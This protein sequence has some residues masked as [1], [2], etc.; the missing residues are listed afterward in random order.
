MKARQRFHFDFVPV[1]G[2]MGLAFVVLFFLMVSLGGDLGSQKPESA[3]YA[4]FFKLF[5]KLGYTVKVQYTQLLPRPDGNLLVY[6]DYEDD[7]ES[8]QTV[9]NKW[10][11]PGGTVLLAGIS[12]ETDPFTK[13]SLEYDQIKYIFGV[14]ASGNPNRKIEK[15]ALKLKEHHL[16]HL[17]YPNKLRTEQIL[18]DSTH[19]PFLYQMDQ[20]R[21]RI[22][23][24]T[25]SNLLGDEILREGRTA[26]Y[27]NR[28]LGDY[29]PKR[30]YVM[31]ANAARQNQPVPLLALLFR[32]KL[33]YVTLQLLLLIALFITWQG[34][35]FGQPQTA[36]PYSRRTLSEHLKAVGNWYQ[37]T[38]SV[39]MV[40][41]INC[42]YFRSMI[43]KVTG[44]QLKEPLRP[45]ELEKLKTALA[46]RGLAMNGEQL[47]ESLT[48]QARI[49]L[50]G[51]QKKE[52]L[53]EQILKVL[54]KRSE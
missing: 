18:L 9:L 35:R 4:L 12:G 53:Q 52:K 44:L 6:F 32:G 11:K 23:V 28:L 21:G 2:V 7:R 46:G 39:A 51:L 17:P 19:G 24:L 16:K 31:D 30:I 49:S 47:R 13:H 50:S 8:W 34:K 22:F 20:G 36:T 15:L 45:E 14:E 3:S 25:D 37:K 33:G 38:G 26:I 29:F 48:S 42:G 43:H 40:D 41:E 27:F 54:S 10:V 5:R 1:L